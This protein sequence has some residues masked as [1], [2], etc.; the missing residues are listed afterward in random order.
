MAKHI[1]LTNEEKEF[2]KERFSYGENLLNRVWQFE[3]TGGDIFIAI[4]PSKRIFVRPKPKY[5]DKITYL[6]AYSDIVQIFF[7]S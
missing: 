5:W 6:V 3:K 4:T 7:T 1:K 2:V